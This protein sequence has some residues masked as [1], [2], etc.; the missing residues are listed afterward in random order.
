LDGAA[1][2]QRDFNSNQ[3]LEDV[4]YTGGGLHAS[5]NHHQIGWHRQGHTRFLQEHNCEDSEEA[6]GRQEVS[7]SGRKHSITIPYS[8]PVSCCIECNVPEKWYNK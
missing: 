6:I 8:E 7:Q 5:G 2:N 1:N 3:Q 4:V